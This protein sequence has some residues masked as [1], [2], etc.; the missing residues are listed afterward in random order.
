MVPNIKENTIIQPMKTSTLSS[1]HEKIKWI[2]EYYI[3]PGGNVNVIILLNHNIH[4]IIQPGNINVKENVI[5]QPD[6]TTNS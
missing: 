1:S 3:H 6:V 4:V 2:S 5:I